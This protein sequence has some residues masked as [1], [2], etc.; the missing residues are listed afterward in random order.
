MT[1]VAS[2]VYDGVA[3]YGKFSSMLG[4]VISS[5]LGLVM[6][7][8]G[9]YLLSKKRIL[10]SRV[11]GKI[12]SIQNGKCEFIQGTYDQNTKRTTTSKWNCTI[13]VSYTV[14]GIPY[15]QRDTTET[16][17][18]HQVGDSVVVYYSPSK[19]S[20]SSVVSDDYRIIGSALTCVSMCIV[21]GAWVWVWVTQRYKVAAAASGA[22]S[23]SSLFTNRL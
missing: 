1:N 17:S 3:E 23:I 13:T 14:N 2:D 21:I 16:S 19:P 22:S 5:V 7:G 4:A 20:V 8:F 6:F 18:K 15:S 9:I 10:T 12:V 11:E